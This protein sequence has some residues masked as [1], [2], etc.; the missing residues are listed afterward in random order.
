MTT[1]PNPV[2]SDLIFQAA[3]QKKAAIIGIVIGAVILT[4]EWVSLRPSTN[5]LKAV[6]LGSTVLLVG[7]MVWC[8]RMASRR[9]LAFSDGMVKMISGSKAK[10]LIDLQKVHRIV[11]RRVRVGKTHY[12]GYFAVLPDRQAELFHEGAY[13]DQFQILQLLEAR[14]GRAVERE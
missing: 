10:E 5:S 12:I 1:P 7:M 8:A 13:T 4:L 11:R 3:S 9:S 2:E 6:F 14:T